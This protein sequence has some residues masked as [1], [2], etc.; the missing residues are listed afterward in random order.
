MKDPAEPSPEGESVTA[1]LTER[2]LA[3]QPRLQRVLD[4]SLPPHVSR[5]LGTVTYHQLEALACLPKEGTTMRQFASAV[6]ISGAAATALANRMIKQGL[7]VRRYEPQDRRQVWLAPT[8]TAQELVESF[9]EWQR[10]S[11]SSVL[12]GLDADQVATFLEVLT[13]LEQAESAEP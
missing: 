3:I 10:E 12:G 4:P 9:R 6:G 2:M 1:D 7:A 11:I 8:D 13:A 5:R